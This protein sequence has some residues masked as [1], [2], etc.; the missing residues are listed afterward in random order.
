MAIGS[1][2]THRLRPSGS[3]PHPRAEQYIVWK[4]FNEV[5]TADNIASRSDEGMKPAGLLETLRL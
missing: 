5:E 2:R 4:K 1:Q 3:A